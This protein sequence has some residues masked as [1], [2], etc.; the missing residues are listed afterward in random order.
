MHG[1]FVVENDEKTNVER[2]KNS[3]MCATTRMKRYLVSLNPL[4]VH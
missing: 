1:Q 4:A 3:F 2:E